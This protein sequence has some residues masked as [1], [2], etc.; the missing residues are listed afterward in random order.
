MLPLTEDLLRTPVNNVTDGIPSIAS[1]RVSN[2]S[3]S[4]AVNSVSVG[5]APVNSV[6]SVNSVNKATSPRYA[7]TPPT[8][9]LS[10]LPRNALSQVRKK[11]PLE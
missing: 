6:N 11:T 7:Y 4:S 2:V 3:Q 9:H 5:S 8:H 1:S 10:M